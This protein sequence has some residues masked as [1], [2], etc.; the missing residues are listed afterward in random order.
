M[1]DLSDLLGAGEVF[2]VEPEDKG[3]TVSYDDVIA[4]EYADLVASSADAVA[5]VAGVVQVAQEDRE[6]FL[7]R[8]DGSTSATQLEGALERFW[9][10]A[11]QAPSAWNETLKG[12]AIAVA[13][14]LRTA[15]FRKQGLRW[16]RHLEG[17]LEQVIELDR[18]ETADGYE[19]VLELG[20][21]DEGVARV[22]H[23]SSRARPTFVGETDCQIWR[24]AG[25]FPLGADAFSVVEVLE[26]E[27]LPLLDAMTTRRAVADAT[28]T[29]AAFN[30]IDRAI[31][32]ALEG[33]VASAHALLQERFDR[34]GARP[35]LLGVAARLGLPPIV[36]GTS[37]D[38]S[39]A[40][41]A[42]LPQ[43]LAA[44]DEARVRFRRTFA[45]ASGDP[46]VLDGSR[47]SLDALFARWRAVVA[48]AQAD[49]A[50]PPR[51]AF[52]ELPTGS[53]SRIVGRGAVER[54]PSAASQQLAEDLASYFGEVLVRAHPGPAW[55][56]VVSSW[57]FEPAVIGLPGGTADVMKRA[58]DFLLSA[59]SPLTPEQQRLY[60]TYN[61]MRVEVDRW[62]EGVGPK[63]GL[64]SRLRRS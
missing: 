61:P 8:T 49:P 16:N 46:R 53:W 12:L 50:D 47:R 22:R 19:A 21:F 18:R 48:R 20:I 40:E 26:Q 6:L 7:V 33:D 59:L 3:F 38:R 1:E 17:A 28:W 10:A 36:T 42:F 11:A 15:G 29:A 57:G 63:R 5:A 34:S 54:A 37:P 52:R 35:H 55:T 44:Q 32:L 64:R 51:S 45:D 39:R 58:I 56:A 13:P 60:R 2:S 23:D 62:L 14:M 24:L 25:S 9:Q 41:E 43:W 31:M 30:V 27:V 4:H